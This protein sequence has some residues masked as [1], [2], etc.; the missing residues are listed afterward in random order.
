MEPI[1]TIKAGNTLGECPLWDGAAMWWT[2]IEERCLFR[3]RWTERTLERFATPERL[4]AFGLVEGGEL[5]VAAFESGFALFDPAEGKTTWLAHTRKLPGV[6]LNDGRVDRQGRFWAG[7]MAEQDEYAGRG[8]LYCL[9]HDGTVRPREGGLTISNSLSWSP[10]GTILYLADS[11]RRT[12]WRYA[13][14]AAS[15]TISDRRVFA[16]TPPGALP[17]GAI[18]DASGRLW[19]AHWGAGRIVRYTP[20]GRIE[21]ALPV[22]ARQPTCVAFGGPGLDLLFVTTARAGLAEP[23]PSDGDVLIYR[24]DAKGLPEERY[25]PA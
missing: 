5:L 3:F 6:R 10:D 25:R 7:E 20:D 17:D 11:P 21:R 19:S 2:D 24:T 22:A 1:G 8:Q 15:G 14:D 13:F 12:I 23:G 4:C 18:T 9:G 16:E